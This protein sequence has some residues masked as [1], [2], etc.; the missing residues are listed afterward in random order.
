[1]EQNTWESLC[2]DTYKQPNRFTTGTDGGS[3]SEPLKY[4]RE[5]RCTKIIASDETEPLNQQSKY[6]QHR[7]DYIRQS[8]FIDLV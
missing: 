7:V 6:N 8:Y 4:F 3:T 1:M 5:P 2:E